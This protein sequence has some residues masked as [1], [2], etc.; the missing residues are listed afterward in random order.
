M[1]EFSCYL[2]IFFMLET[3]DFYEICF[4]SVF[5][6]NCISKQVGHA[7]KKKHILLISATDDLITELNKL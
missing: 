4:L 1:D 3:S 5:Q 6:V 2:R 7:H